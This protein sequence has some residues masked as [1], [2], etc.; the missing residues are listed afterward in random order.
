MARSTRRRR[1]EDECA[2][3]SLNTSVELVNAT[4]EREEDVIEPEDNASYPLVPLHEK[5]SDTNWSVLHEHLDMNQLVLEISE[6]SRAQCSNAPWYGSVEQSLFKNAKQR[7][8]L[9]PDGSKVPYEE[10]KVLRCAFFKECGCMA[11]IRWVRSLPEGDFRLEVGNWPHGD[12]SKFPRAK[13]RGLPKFLL[14]STL[15]SPSNMENTAA[16]AM[17]KARRIMGNDMDEAMQGKFAAARKKAHIRTLGAIVPTAIKGT[18]GGIEEFIAQKTR[19]ALES[20]G[21]FGIHSVYVC[22]EPIIDSKTNNVSI[23]YSS[24]NLLLN[25]YRQSLSP[26]QDLVQ[27]DT[28]HRLVLEGHNNLLLGCVDAAQNFHVIGYGICAREDH[29]AHAHVTSCLKEE[30]EKVVS[31]RALKQEGI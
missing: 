20:S 24:E 31:Q 5:I 1:A 16:D 25:A 28:T 10:V 18:I 30:M 6:L 3:Q 8:K 13:K 12:H 4:S 17:Q 19:S 7:L 29:V 26:V 15:H 9:A 27:V 21:T 11:R 23:A 22:G 14:Q 2:T